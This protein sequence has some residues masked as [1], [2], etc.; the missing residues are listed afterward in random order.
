MKLKCVLLSLFSAALL[1]ACV[2]VPTPLKGDYAEISPRQVSSHDL[3]SETVRW[4]GEIIKVEPKKELTCFEILSREL[5]SQARPIVRDRSEGRFIACRTG[6]YDPEVYTKGREI[7]V[8]G[9]L[10]GSEQHPVGEFTYSYPHVDAQVIYLWPKRVEYAA[11]RY[12]YGPW[13][14]YDPFWRGWWG[15]SVIIVHPRPVP[16]ARSRR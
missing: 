9:K 4:G 11:D 16:L 15:P 12:G 13:P 5:S 3:T 1:S 7:T 10:I 8:I 14:Y 2:T 6:F